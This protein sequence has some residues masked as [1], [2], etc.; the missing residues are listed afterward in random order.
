MVDMYVKKEPGQFAIEPAFNIGLVSGIKDGALHLLE[1]PDDVEGAIRAAAFS[2]SRNA[3]HRWRLMTESCFISDEAIMKD[4]SLL[5]DAMSVT[6]VIDGKE[7]R[8]QG[9][10]RLP[11]NPV[12]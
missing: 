7:T 8:P 11:N 2:A 1:H 4:P 5:S 12:E 6:W 3:I 10:K 9:P